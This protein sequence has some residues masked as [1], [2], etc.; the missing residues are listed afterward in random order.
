MHPLHSTGL[1]SV[2]AQNGGKEKELPRKKLSFQ[3]ARSTSTGFL[4]EKK[5]F[6]LLHPSH[7]VP[8]ACG[9][10]GVLESEFCEV[11]DERCAGRALDQQAN[12]GS[13]SSFPRWP[14]SVLDAEEILPALHLVTSGCCKWNG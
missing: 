8:A 4:G 13:K 6:W 5:R 7:T 14:L 3:S 12:K 9:D 10:K 2:S 11:V 1:L